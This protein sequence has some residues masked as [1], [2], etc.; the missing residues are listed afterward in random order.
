M[1]SAFASNVDR[2]I[3]RGNAK[4]RAILERGVDL[5]SVEGLDGISIGRLAADL[6]ISKS[7]VV[8]HFGSKLEL[9]LAIIAAAS[10]QFVR[11]VVDPAEREPAGLARLWAL[12]SGWLDHVARP[13]TTGGCFFSAVGAEF[14][15][16]PGRIRDALAAAHRT[17]N[18]VLIAQ[19]ETA[20]AAGEIAATADPAQIA[21]ELDALVRHANLS[22]QLHHDR[23]AFARTRSAIRRLLDSLAAGDASQG[24]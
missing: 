12:C 20:R 19:L 9:Q 22:N 23:Q 3:E 4:R 1:D 7:G 11:H 18:A 16:R 8:L 2:R 5:A 21:Y 15:S 14:N 13:T 24:D 6:G 17:W 10:D